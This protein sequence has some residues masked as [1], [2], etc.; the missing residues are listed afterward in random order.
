MAQLDF[1]S[2]WS[3]WR[4]LEGER[5]LRMLDAPAGVFT[6]VFFVKGESTDE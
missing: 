5:D 3:T 4:A 6:G 1:Y 2:D